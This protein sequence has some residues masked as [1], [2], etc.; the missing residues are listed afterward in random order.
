MASCKAADEFDF[1]W[2][3]LKETGRNS[4]KQITVWRNANYKPN[5]ADVMVM[6]S[7]PL[8]SNDLGVSREFELAILKNGSLEAAAYRASLFGRLIDENMVSPPNVDRMRQLASSRMNG[9][10]RSRTIVQFGGG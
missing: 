9:K 7:I 8:S 3:S 2:L 1:V 10:P 4:E 5:T 6:M